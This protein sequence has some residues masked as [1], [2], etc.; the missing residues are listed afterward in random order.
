MKGCVADEIK[1]L[2]KEK[3]AVIL[4]HYYCEDAV[5]A[6]SDYAGSTADIIR[7]AGESDA[8]EFIICT[9]V[10]VSYRLRADHPEKRF[11]FCDPCPC[12]ADM[13]YNTPEKIL[14]ALKTGK[15]A[16]EIDG[17]TRLG[18]LAPLEKMLELAK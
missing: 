18:A 1:A 13:K 7:Y 4:A 17:E 12:C 5:L 11:Y 3:N 15:G 6:L 10:G 14:E 8:T 2:K 9:E 16:V